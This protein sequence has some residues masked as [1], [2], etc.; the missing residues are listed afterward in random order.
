MM[1]RH[2]R[3]VCLILACVGAWL[4]GVAFGQ[5]PTIDSGSASKP[6]G[7]GNSLG[8]MPGS[9]GS[10]L[11]S[12]PGGGQGTGSGA[13]DS[14]APVSGRT[15]SAGTRA[16]SS[17]SNPSANSG[18]PDEATGFAAPKPVAT[19]NT[20]SYGTYSIPTGGDD[21]GPADGLTLDAAIDLMLRNNLDLRSKFYE[22]PQADA[23]ILGA[24]LRANPI[25]YADAQLVPYGRYSKER[26]GGQT[27]Y[28]VNVS[29]PL[30]VSKKRLART[31]Y[32]TRAKRV[33]EAQY[34]NA[35]RNSI[36]QLYGSFVNVLAAR[37]A[38]YYARA[39]VEGLK[40]LYAVTLELYRKEQ[41]TIADVKRIQ[42]TLNAS[43]VGL[44]D[45]GESLRKAK[46]DLGTILN[47][48]SAESEALDIRGA[49]H[50]LTEQTPQVD[51]LVRMAVAI[52]PDV[53]SYRLGVK[54]AESNVRLQLANRYQD[55][56]VLY[57]PYTLQDNTPQG[58]KSPTSWALGVTVP[59]PVYNRNQGGIA[60][61]KLN[62]TQTQIESAS[63]ERQVANEVRQAYYEYEVTGKMIRRIH[64]ELEPA[65]RAVR[66]ATYK[67]YSGGEKNKIDYLNAQREYQDVA[68]QYLDTLIRHRR[69]MLGLNTAIG[70]RVFP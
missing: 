48:T 67:L 62:V 32:A 66:D 46:L 26:P 28:D 54:T 5:A 24:A 44:E 43:Q 12:V 14:S 8:T 6:G 1:G 23:D 18:A 45:A 59:L 17:V 61:A 38:V 19:F 49:I 69:S 2:I 20:P 57:Q 13:P 16:P 64:D 15:G 36:D 27:Q 34:Q 56:Y 60:R 29:Y 11:G 21:E 70:Q 10:I 52:R 22:I 30:D 63:I 35:V 3:Q 50:D 65:A 53:V 37:Q 25:F 51:E 31:L 39:S 7:T 58:T 9:G 40:N 68:K 42:V 41:S 33:I 47:L 55:V 4:P